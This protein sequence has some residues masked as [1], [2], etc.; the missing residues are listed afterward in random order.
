MNILEL[1][2]CEVDSGWVLGASGAVNVEVTLVED[3]GDVGVFNVDVLVGDVVDTTEA[4]VGASPGLEAGSGLC[5][6]SECI[7]ERGN[8]ISPG[9]SGW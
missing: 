5:H 2:V 3:N 9:C 7:L 4:D 6:V 8:C 1:D